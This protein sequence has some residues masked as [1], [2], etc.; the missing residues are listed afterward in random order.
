MASG[1]VIRNSDTRPQRRSREDST[2][3]VEVGRLVQM[4]KEDTQIRMKTHRIRDALTSL[5]YLIR[6]RKESNRNAYEYARSGNLPVYA[7]HRI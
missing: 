3:F 5:I 4:L 6:K 7:K 2:T 1:S